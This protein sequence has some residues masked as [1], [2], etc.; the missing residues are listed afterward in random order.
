MC[1]ETKDCEKH[2][3]HQVTKAE[4]DLLKM[5]AVHLVS[6]GNKD[7]LQKRVSAS[8]TVSTNMLSRLCD[9]HGPQPHD[10]HCSGHG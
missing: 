4:Q 1:R 9:N 7:Q 6:E 5:G 2:Q 8:I 10:L 3:T